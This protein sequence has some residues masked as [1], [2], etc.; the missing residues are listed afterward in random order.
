MPRAWPVV[1]RQ[2]VPQAIIVLRELVLW[3]GAR[4]MMAKSSPAGWPA[5]QPVSESTALL[6][7]AGLVTREGEEGC[8]QKGKAQGDPG[9]KNPRALAVCA[10]AAGLPRRGLEAT[11][12][13]WLARW[14]EAQRATHLHTLTGA[15]RDASDSGGLGVLHPT[16]ICRVAAAAGRDAT[17][18][19]AGINRC[20]YPCS[21][22]SAVPQTPAG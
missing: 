14:P 13:G 18:S 5:G 4:M 6:W 17:R 16:P 8:R 1:P 22:L 21:R 2:F 15:S 7:W 10:C 11:V 9:P 3:K 12:A 19:R 20:L